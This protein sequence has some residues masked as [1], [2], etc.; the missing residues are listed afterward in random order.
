MSDLGRAGSNPVPGSVGSVQ[1]NRPPASQP[2]A[3]RNS[4]ANLRETSR[5]SGGVTQPFLQPFLTP[6]A[7]IVASWARTERQLRWLAPSTPSPL[8]PEKVLQWRKP[9]GH[10]LVY[11]EDARTLLGY[12]ELNPMRD[13]ARHYW[14]GHLVVNPERRGQGIGR[15]F[16]RALLE[17]AFDQISATKVSLLVFPANAAARACYLHAGFREVCEEFHQ[18]GGRGPRH[19]LLRLE[20]L[21][22]GQCKM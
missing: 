11:M 7:A 21:G 13:E 16:V 2:D 18:F 10:A 12:G 8:T 20:T 5:P 9:D 3:L 17:R 15:A 1:S 19:R 14:L 6:H 22:N 4:P